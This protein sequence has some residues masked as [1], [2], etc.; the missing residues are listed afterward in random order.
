MEGDPEG[1]E[2]AVVV[3]IGVAETAGEVFFRE[4]V[5][6]SSQGQRKDGVPFLECLLCF[7]RMD[8]IRKSSG[9]ASEVNAVGWMIDVV[10]Y[11]EIISTVS[12]FAQE[13]LHNVLDITGCA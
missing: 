12:I 9:S 10:F 13:L 11:K 7:F 8:E 2:G 5:V 6:E 3:I 1:P 4:D